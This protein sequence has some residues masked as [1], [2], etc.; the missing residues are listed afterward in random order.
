[1][2]TSNVDS[3]QFAIVTTVGQTKLNLLAAGEQL[4]IT[5][6]AFGDGNGSVVVPDASGESLTHEIGREAVT[7]R[8]SEYLAAGVLMSSAMTEKYKGQWLREVGL[9]DAD[10]D[11]IVW[12][13]MA[14]ALVSMFSQ[15]TIMVH[16][17]LSEKDN[18]LVVVDTS[19]KYASVEY[20]DKAFG[21][22][23]EDENPHEQYASAEKFNQ[24]LSGDGDKHSAGDI[25]FKVGAT[26]LPD[27][28]QGAI[29]TL[30][31]STKKKTLTMRRVVFDAPGAHT[32][33]P[34]I[35]IASNI[36]VTL[37]GAGGGGQGGRT[38]GRG[39]GGGGATITGYS[40]ATS[41]SFSVGAGGGGGTPG[42][43]G[44][45]GG[46]TTYRNVHAGGGRG[47]ATNG[48]IGGSPS[49]TVVE[50]TD[51]LF[52]YGGAGGGGDAPVSGAST[53]STGQSSGASDA[54]VKYGVGGRPPFNST[55]V[56]GKG[57]D[58]VVMFEFLVED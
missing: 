47:G 24:H 53:M 28:V 11:L 56:G 7:M 33:T 41:F 31:K 15:R 12:G 36:K 54:Y 38:G 17:P 55:A 30:V 35:N 23:L 4:V 2:T 57:A 26:G 9:I 13:A 5:T 48:G 58:G 42:G 19:N 27:N 21:A 32:F 51:T 52:I 45:A 10:G 43:A 1:M 22:H 37:I 49:G 16:L 34:P 46:S 29:E 25:V 50:L 18:I 3:E 14:P 44:I 39:A 6:I 40:T 8:S 20:V